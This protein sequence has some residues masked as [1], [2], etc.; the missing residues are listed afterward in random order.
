M[1]LNKIMHLSLLLGLIVV[2][3]SCTIGSSTVPNNNI[4]IVYN[5][6]GNSNG[7]DQWANLT[8]GSDGFLYGITSRG[9]RNNSGVIYK[10]LPSGNNYQ[11]IFDLNNNSNTFA[12]LIEYNNQ[13]FGVTQGAGSNNV[14]TI[15]K[16][17][18]D[19]SNYNLLHSFSIAT[20]AA[21]TANLYWSKYNNKFYGTTKFGGNESCPLNPESSGSGNIAGCG[22]IYSFDPSNNNF[23]MLYAF[24]GTVGSEPFFGFT[25]LDT[26]PA[27]SNPILYATL[28]FGGANGFGSLISWNMNNENNESPN[29]VDSFGNNNY[30]GQCPWPAP[31][32][33]NGIAYGS[34]WAGGTS[35]VGTI[36]RF[37]DAFTENIQF[38]FIT[39]TGSRPY[40][41]LLLA[42][43]GN[44]YGTTYDGGTGDCGPD[45]YQASGCG[46][47]FKYTPGG[48]Y[49]VIANFNGNNGSYPRAGLIEVD[50]KLFGVTTQ[51]GP[52]NNGVIYQ[53][54]FTN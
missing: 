19:G 17:N 50:G 8:L 15:F 32:F 42:S 30:D 16:I 14:G 34:T 21:P 49:S 18:F 13:L 52:A 2:T 33:V 11:V 10:I 47:V 12:S 48:Q 1:M 35:N 25:Q 23:S 28:G 24:D 22:T 39:Q 3:N 38:N 40:S 26:I 53:I 51:G 54:N 9:G 7:S 5:F 27:E 37:D 36:Y 43:D 44:L 29:L 41:G 31:T 6:A 46:T 20:G 45:Q 4:K